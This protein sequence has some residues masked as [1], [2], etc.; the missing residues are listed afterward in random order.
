MLV[1]QRF[2]ALLRGVNV[3]KGKRVPMA[4]LKAMLEGLG[5]E[6]VSTLLNNGNA[7]FTSSSRSTAK[8]A[9]AI[10]TALE[11]RLGV[12]T[13]VIVKSAAELDAIIAASPIAPPEAEHSRYLVAFAATSADLHGL[14]PLHALVQPPERFV[15]T[16]AAA[17]LH[18][19]AGIL[20]S[21]I[22]EAL[23]GKAGRRVTTRNWATVL[24][25][26]ARV[27]LTPEATG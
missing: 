19:P 12:S 17:F 5:C 6:D 7:V 2:I 8:H 23:L 24:K 13:P 26:Q 3:G 9:A 20:Q 11:E 1:R 25:L 21:R 16:P 22:G 15:I 10:A 27:V 18:C 4:E 14:E